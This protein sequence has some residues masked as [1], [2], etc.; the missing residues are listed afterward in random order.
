MGLFGKKRA[1]GSDVAV[2]EGAFAGAALFGAADSLASGGALSDVEFRHVCK[3]Y[4]A[5]EVLRRATFMLPGGGVRCLMAPSGSGK[6]TLFRVLLGLEH[7]DSG[8]IRG[9]SPGRISMMFQEDRLCET[10]TPVENVALVLPAETRRA[11]VAALLAG[12]LPT[13]CLG[14][15]AMELSGGM[16]RRV[17]LAR[18]VASPS[19]LIVLDE[20]FAG[21]DQAT[22]EKVIAFVLRHRAGR[23][24]LVATHGEDDARLLGAE[25]VNLADVQDGGVSVTGATGIG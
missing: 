22:K 15:P 17:S 24:L 13:D 3:A 8:E 7:A 19:D 25:R 12:I 14:Q 4:G 16:R 21:L 9:I 6:T 1:A 20:P 11:D 18:A 2:G 23:T 5:N 10:L